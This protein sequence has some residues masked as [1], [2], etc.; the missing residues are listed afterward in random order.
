[1]ALRVGQGARVGLFTGVLSVV[2]LGIF[3]A[4]KAGLSPDQYRQDV[5]ETI[6]VLNEQQARNPSPVLEQLVHSLADGTRGLVLNG[7]LE[8]AS[9]MVFLPLVSGISGA[10]AAALMRPKNR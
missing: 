2:F 6:K 8:V 4:A 9:A 3:L 7:V 1:M 5:E 10:L